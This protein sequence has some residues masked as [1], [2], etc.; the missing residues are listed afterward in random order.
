MIGNQLRYFLIFLFLTSHPNI[1]QHPLRRVRLQTKQMQIQVDFELPKRSPSDRTARTCLRV[2][3]GRRAPAVRQHKLYDPTATR[4]NG[5][6]TSSNA[7]KTCNFT[8]LMAT[9]FPV[10][11][12]DNEKSRSLLLLTKENARFDI[13]NQNSTYQV[14]YLCWLMVLGVG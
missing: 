14:G 12:S 6:E 7:A 5:F 11:D 10:N 3:G 9:R 2:R 8:A 4:N 13:Q 1:S